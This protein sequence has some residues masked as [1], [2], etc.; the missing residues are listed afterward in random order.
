MPQYGK[1]NPSNAENTS[2]LF[3]FQ[4]VPL[5]SEKLNHWNGNI[6]AGFVLLQQ[7]LTALLAK[8]GLAI[9]STGSVSSLQVQPTEPA[10][11]QVQIQPGWAILGTTLA[12]SNE[13]AIHPLDEPVAPPSANPRID[14]VCL[15]ELGAFE[16]VQ[17]E[18]NAVPTPP[19]IPDGAAGLAQ[20]YH[21]VGS[22]Q[23]LTNDNGIDSYIIDT[24]PRFL[25][26]EAH[27]HGPD[28]APS[29]SPDG[30]RVEFSTQH[31]FRQGTLDVFINGVIQTP[32]V[33]YQEKLD[34]TGYQ[35]SSPPLSHYRIQH[36]YVIDYEQN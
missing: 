19:P 13:T 34:R 7:I 17:G 33:D 14:C 9:I 8:N 31:V 22:T 35:F 29:E 3:S 4:E 26:G 23:I 28:K 1:Y 30:S 18:E 24:R 2:S 32:D 20:L 12:G 21:R 36:R 5:T 27:Q 6:E 10:A 11:L 16:I 25:L 15:T